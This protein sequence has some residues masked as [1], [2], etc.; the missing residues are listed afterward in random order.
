VLQTVNHKTGGLNLKVFYTNARSPTR[1]MTELRHIIQTGN[2]DIAC[3][4]ETWFTC[5]QEEGEKHISGYRLYSKNRQSGRAGGV[6]IYT[7]AALK[8]KQLPDTSAV[9]ETVWC[10]V[11]GVFI[12][13]S[14][15]S[16]NIS[17]QDDTLLCEQIGSEVRRQRQAML[18]VRDFN[19]PGVDWRKHYTPSSAEMYKDVADSHN[20][21]QYMREPTRHTAT[22]DL[23]F[24][25]EHVNISNLKTSVLICNSDHNVITCD[26]TAHVDSGRKQDGGVRLKNYS[27]VDWDKLSRAL[28]V[29]SQQQLKDADVTT[30]WQRC[31]AIVDVAVN[32][33]VPTVKTSTRR[34]YPWNTDAGCSARQQKQHA[35]SAY[36]LAPR[37]HSDF[38]QAPN[39]YTRILRYAIAKYEQSVEVRDAKA[40]FQYAAKR[41]F[42]SDAPSMLEVDGKEVHDK[43]LCAQKFSKYFACVFNQP[44]GT[45]QRTTTTVCAQAP[46]GFKCLHPTSFTMQDVYTVLSGLNNKRSLGPDDIPNLLLK[47]CRQEI[48]LPLSI[49]FTESMAEGHLPQD[50]GDAIVIPIHKKG[51]KVV[52][53]NYRPISLTFTVLKIMEK[54]ICNHTANHVHSN[55]LV[56]E[57]QYGFR[58]NLNC[59]YQLLHYTDRLTK[60]INNGLNVDVL[61]LDMQKAFDTVPIVN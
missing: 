42:V 22:L 34:W 26:V 17:T 57:T 8:V 12:G 23:V 45:G 58:K 59:E 1:K 41:R 33:V 39:K 21:T 14:Y 38:R 11:G 40:F 25:N 44:G 2:Y 9:T 4:G 31:R 5:E 36:K 10:D 35:W 48:A 60:L 30:A 53:E 15:R 50:W 16:I 24:A 27:K 49:L 47:R 32:D 13:C 19:M 43:H 46:T 29:D 56:T 54:I 61:Y 18:I 28:C 55:N 37:S 6:A 3:V 7:R 52:C 20:L 51:S